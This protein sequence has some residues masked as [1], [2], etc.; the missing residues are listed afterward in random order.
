[1]VWFGEGLDPRV[2]EQAATE[3]EQCDLCL[4]V[5]TLRFS[6]KF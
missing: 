2:M 4:V 3:L 6:L 5:S 1:M